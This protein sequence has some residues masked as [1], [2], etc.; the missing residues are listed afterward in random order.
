MSAPA[1][2]SAH[3]DQGRGLSADEA[4][5]RLLAEG[6]NELPRG[7]RH[8]FLASVLHALGEP[9]F[10]LLLVAAGIYMLLGDRVEA[11]FLLASV[12]AIVALTL[13]QERR[14]G[15]RARGAARPRPV[16]RALV[17]RDNA[18]R[19]I[20]GREVVRGDLLVVREGD[21]V[22]GD[23]S[24]LRAADLRVDESLITGES[25]AV[26]KH[27]RATAG[28]NRAAKARAPV[29]R[30]AGREG[31][32]PRRGHRDRRAHGNGT[33][34]PVAG[35]TGD[36]VHA[37]QRETR[38]LVRM[39]AIFAVMVCLS[40]MVL[41]YGLTRGDWLGAVLA[42]LT[43][44]MAM[45]PEEFPVVLTV[46]LALGAWRMT[47]RQ[48]ADAARGRDRGARRGNRAVRRQDRHADART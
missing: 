21:R 2:A 31:P 36:R 29:R 23:G 28:E 4:R 39:F 3:V 20:P 45:L 32:R 12:G 42:G 48:R 38:R 47:R 41:R 17:I 34:R 40:L 13:D 33:H 46:F 1:P 44:A 5:A 16:R 8:G 9:M 19:R 26:D 18:E 27:R 25:V 7:R 37:L 14:D 10:L 6:P 35:L 11:L 22:A 15:P 24:V 43:L 30:H